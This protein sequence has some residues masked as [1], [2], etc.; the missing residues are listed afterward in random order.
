MRV[1]YLD[2]LENSVFAQTVVEAGGLIF[3]QDGAPAH[4][5]DTVCTDL[6][7]QFPGRWIGRGGLI[8]GPLWDPYVT[9]M[10]FLFWG[11]IK[12]TIYSK[13]ITA[14]IIAV[15]MDVVSQVWG[16]VEFCFDVCRT[17]TGAHIEFH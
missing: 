13:R 14:A 7:E 9:P 12:D 11:D 15:P 5:G 10:D 4:S 17:I 16:E 3:Q 6:Y 2:I 8:N 1:V